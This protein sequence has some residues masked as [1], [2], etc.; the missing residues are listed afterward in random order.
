MKSEQEKRLREMQLAHVGKLMAGL[1]HEFKNHLAIIKE[2]NG[3]IQ[4]LLSLEDPDQ[5]KQKERYEKIIAG[6]NERIEQAAEMC[7][8]LSGFAHR[9]DHP[10]SSFSAPEVIQEEIYLLSRFARQKQVNLTASFEEELPLILNNPSLLQ[11]VLFCIIGPALEVL[12]P[13]GRI[14]ISV[15]PQEDSIRIVIKAEGE[16]KY[17]ETKTD[18]WQQM[19]PE[20]LEILQA[21]LAGEINKDG[22]GETVIIVSSVENFRP[23][24]EQ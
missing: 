11:F 8:F 22:I 10:I 23:D 1:S 7:R 2:L 16:N 20:A 18:P 13:D 3:L 17:P 19:L 6:V 21:E 12:K 14:N 24:D 5:P 15:H 9:T 4:D